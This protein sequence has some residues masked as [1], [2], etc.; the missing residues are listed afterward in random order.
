MTIYYNADGAEFTMD[1]IQDLA[2]QAGVTPERYIADNIKLK[3]I[4]VIK[5]SK[6]NQIA[7]NFRKLLSS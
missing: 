7:D 3:Q 1:V 6:I 5:P 2:D 4:K